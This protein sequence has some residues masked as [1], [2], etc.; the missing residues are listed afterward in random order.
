MIDDSGE[1]LNSLKEIIDNSW[2]LANESRE[3]MTTAA[4]A[5][6]NSNSN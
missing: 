4:V 2:K 1:L 5:N 3:Q 6:K